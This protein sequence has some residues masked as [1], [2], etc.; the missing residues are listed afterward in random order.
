MK[1]FDTVAIHAA[2]LDLKGWNYSND[3]IEK[4]FVF[5]NFK[6][7]LVAMIRIGFEAEHMDHHPDWSNAYNKLNIKLRTHSAD[8]ITENDFSLAKKIEEIVNT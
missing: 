5:H 7:A 4:S 8:G 1:K 2:L 6:D 3:Y